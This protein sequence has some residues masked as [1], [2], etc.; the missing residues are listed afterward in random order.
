M[1]QGMAQRF[2][3][4]S[5]LYLFGGRA[6]M[7]SQRLPA[8]VNLTAGMPRADGDADETGGR[9]NAAGWLGAL[10]TID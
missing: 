8:Y 9:I 5:N 7:L 1:T 2:C 4:A 3:H 6:M 10:K